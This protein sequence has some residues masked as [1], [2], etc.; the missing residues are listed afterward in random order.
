MLMVSMYRLRRALSCSSYEGSASVM[1][2]GS[3]RRAEGTSG[4]D[5]VAIRDSDQGKYPDRADPAS[6][7]DCRGGCLH[8]KFTLLRGIAGSGAARLCRTA[9]RL[10]RLVA[11]VDQWGAAC[12]AAALTAFLVARTAS[13]DSSS[14]TSATDRRAPSSP[15]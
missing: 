3:A 15:H 4:R 8:P 9:V 2:V 7:P 11:G 5:D 12:L 6:T 14:T 10:P 1:T 13:R